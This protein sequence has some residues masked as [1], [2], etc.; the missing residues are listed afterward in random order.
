MLQMKANCEQCDAP[1]AADMDN[2]FICSFECTFCRGCAEDLLGYRCPNCGGM[3]TERP[4][5]IGDALRRNPALT[6]EQS[7]ANSA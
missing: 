2:A 3:L 1:T 4:T 7:R 5:R 6:L